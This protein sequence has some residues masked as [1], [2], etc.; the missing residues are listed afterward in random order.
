MKTTSTSV[1]LDRPGT[2]RGAAPAGTAP[3]EAF[4]I[5]IDQPVN[6]GTTA[7][8]I[9]VANDCWRMTLDVTASV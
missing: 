9:D 3:H 5:G 4:G 8:W 1:H 6:D 2:R 7:V